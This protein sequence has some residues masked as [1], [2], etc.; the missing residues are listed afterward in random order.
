[1]GESKMMQCGPVTAT[2]WHDKRDVRLLSTNCDATVKTTVDRRINK[3]RTKTA[4]PC[5]L[6][7]KLYNEFMGGVDKF[8]QLSKY[9]NVRRKHRKWWKYVFYFVLNSCIVNSFILFEM[10]RQK[11][12]PAWKLTML[13]FQ[14]TLALRLMRA[15][16]QPVVATPTQLHHTPEK[17]TGHLRQ[18]ALC[19]T[20]NKK[21]NSGRVKRTSW[22]CTACKVPLCKNSCFLEYHAGKCINIMHLDR[23][24]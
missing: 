8:D 12:V 6:H 13:N 9:Y 1:M 11:S 19:T 22:G 16:K 2:L 5:P 3:S 15:G 17:L 10:D 24:T 21:S 23:S 7:L 20:Q 14:K 18:C 4:V